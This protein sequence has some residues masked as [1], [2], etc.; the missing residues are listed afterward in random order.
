MVSLLMCAVDMD[1]SPLKLDSQFVIDNDNSQIGGEFIS[2]PEY[3]SS[4]YRKKHAVYPSEGNFG[5][6]TPATNKKQVAPIPKS[7]LNVESIIR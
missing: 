1:L 5:K 3:T 2:S 6:K 4:N 7:N